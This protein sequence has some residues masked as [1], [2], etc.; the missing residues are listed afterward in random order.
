MTT[1]LDP[2]TPVL[3]GA[4]QRTHRPAD[5]PVP[6]PPVLM[7]EV[8]RSALADAQAAIGADELLRRVEVA[9]SIDLFSWPVPDPAAVMAAELGITPRATVRTARG[10]NGPV[11]LLGD[12]SSRVASGEV[13]VALISF[14][15]AFKPFMAAVRG[16]PATGWP[17][18]GEDVAPTWSVGADHEPSNAAETAAGMLAPIFYYPLFEHALRATAGRTRAEQL[19]HAARIWGRFAEVASTNPYAWSREAPT[20]P[21]VLGTPSPENRLVS[22]PYPKLLNANISVD[23]AAALVLMSAG[24]AEAAGIPRERWVVVHATAG[25][26]DHWFVTERARLDRSPAIAAGGRAALGHAGIS[27]DDAAHLDLYSCFP[28]AVQVAAGELG[29][30]LFDPA[31][32]PTVTGGLTFAG[33]P[34]NGYVLHALATLVGR[35]REDPTGFGVSTAVGWYLTKHGIAVLG[36]PGTTPARPFAH[37]DVQAEVDA[38]PRREVVHGEA[39]QA[40]IETHTALYDHTGTPTMAIATGITADGRRA[41]GSSQDPAVVAAVTG[42]ADP[43][44]MPARFDGAGGLA[45]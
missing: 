22:D 23:Q 19:A 27:I 1:A 30:D 7:A 38:L 25:A 31:R 2:R 44:G 42:D 6:A 16:G 33:G 20:D 35:L 43:L 8:A 12:L 18:Q 45:V 5:G 4:A 15:E 39:A 32:Y 3:V 36:G 41:I 40:P 10:G 34:A 14:A 21:E 9:A 29:V 28:S 37:H 24:A 26:T 13:D 17:E 11:A